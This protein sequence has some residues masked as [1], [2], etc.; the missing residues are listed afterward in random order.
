MPNLVRHEHVEAI[1]RAARAERQTRILPLR[2]QIEHQIEALRDLVNIGQ[3]DDVK[4]DRY[5]D[6]FAV[7]E[8][9]P[10]HFVLLPDGDRSLSLRRAR[11]ADKQ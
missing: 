9:W 6:R 2:H 7:L 5:R 3:V 4:R 1:G 11:Y 10:Q 8:R